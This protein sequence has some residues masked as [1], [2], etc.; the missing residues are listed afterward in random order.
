MKETPPWVVDALGEQ[1]F[2]ALAEGMPASEVWSL[3]LSV[4]ERRSMKRTPAAALH[5]QSEAVA[6]RERHGRTARCI[7]VSDVIPLAV[8]PPHHA[9]GQ[10][11]CLLQQ[12]RQLHS[13]QRS[14]IDDSA[15]IDK[16]VV[17]GIDLT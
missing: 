5:F 7:L 11:P 6:R 12:S 17:H 8:R 15:A 13:C 16:A 2:A 14:P 9:G 4:I 3:L 1:G 10:A